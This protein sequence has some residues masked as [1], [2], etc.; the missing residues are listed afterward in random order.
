[1]SLCSAYPVFVILCVAIGGAIA[2]FTDA[3]VLY[4]ISIGLAVGFAP[5]VLL[6]IIYS[7]MMAWRPDRPTCRCRKCQYMHYESVWP[8]EITVTEETVYEYRCPFC[9][10]TYRQKGKRF[11]EVSSDGSEIPYMVISKWGRW[12]AENTEAPPTSG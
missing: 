9:S 4:G 12:Q 1:M 10:R 8:E 6:G 5:L 11:W 7:L 2:H 3:P